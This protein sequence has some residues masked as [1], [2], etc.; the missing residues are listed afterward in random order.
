MTRL[1]SIP[2]T[3]AILCALGSIAIALSVPHFAKHQKRGDLGVGRT[4]IPLPDLFSA[5]LEELQGGLVTGS[6]SSV[7]L[8]TVPAPLFRI[9]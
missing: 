3:I 2:F 7:D 8:V 4:G 9:T 5:T 6:F 1:P